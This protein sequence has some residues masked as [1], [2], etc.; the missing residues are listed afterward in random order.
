MYADDIVLIAKNEKELQKMIDIVVKYSHKWRFELN[1]KKTEI[2]I[3]GSKGKKCYFWLRAF[4]KTG[5]R[6]D[7]DEVAAAAEEAVEVV[8]VKAAQ[9]EG[10]DVLKEVAKAAAEAAAVLGMTQLKVVS[11]YTYLGVD[12][13][14]NRNW[15][16][17]KGKAISKARS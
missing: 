13:K 4:D 3:F 7:D 10:A 2:V 1:N 5:E 17:F 11:K 6:G 15:K 8:A 9:D 14:Q 16:D 12:V